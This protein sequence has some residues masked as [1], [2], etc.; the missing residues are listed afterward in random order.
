MHIICCL[1][2]MILLF[3]MNFNHKRKNE[4]FTISNLMQIVYT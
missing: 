2:E 3:L 1:Q 4:K